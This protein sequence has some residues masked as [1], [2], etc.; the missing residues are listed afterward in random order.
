[1]AYGDFKDLTRKTVSDKILPKKAFAIAQ[2]PNY[3]GYLASMV[4]K[5]LIKKRLG[6][7]VLRDKN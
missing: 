4:Y 7:V 1:M 5:F 6:Y 2:I 3:V